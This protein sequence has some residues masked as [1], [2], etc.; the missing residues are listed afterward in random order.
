V[1][2]KAGRK[3]DS[4]LHGVATFA[5]LVTDTTKVEALGVIQVTAD[6]DSAMG[7]KIVRDRLQLCDS[8]MNSLTPA[9]KATT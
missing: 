8:R 4:G 6:G 1:N 2:E 5:L 3:A 9:P 7:K